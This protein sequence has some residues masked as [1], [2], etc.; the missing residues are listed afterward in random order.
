[1][2]GRDVLLYGMS[3]SEAYASLL[4]WKA[5]TP[6]LHTFVPDFHRVQI[7]HWIWTHRDRLG[8]DILDVG[9]DN[10]RQWLG[11][12]Y[13]TV[14]EYDED[15]RGDVCALPFGDT[16][17]DGVVLTEVLEHCVNPPAAIAE[18][19]RVLRP[20]GLLLVTS[21]F[22]W[23]DHRTTTYADY[24]RFTAQGWQLLLQAFR[25]VVITACAWTPEGEDA[26]HLARRFEAWGFADHVQAT[27]GYLCEG[28]KP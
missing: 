18:V 9:V 23:P 25:D 22:L 1:M 28:H 5:T 24:W 20:N 7:E 4:Q 13:V 14:G 26:Y 12:G 11:P 10:P 2:S 6:E 19:F 15:V 16:S 17:F 27:T 8:R 21:P 3:R